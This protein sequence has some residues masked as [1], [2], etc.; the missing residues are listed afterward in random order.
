ML[1][2]RVS[3]PGPLAYESG[4]LPIALRGP[5]SHLQK[6]TETSLIT[7]SDRSGPIRLCGPC[8]AA[9][10]GYC[11]FVKGWALYD[12][13]NVLLS[14]CFITNIVLLNFSQIVKTFL[15]PFC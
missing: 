11:M 1:P 10:A 5:A 6:R 7:E 2:D 14:V 3:N 15:L 4:V 8:I 12:I 13:Y 9:I